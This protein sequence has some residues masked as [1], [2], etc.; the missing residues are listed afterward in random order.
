MTSCA[1][2]FCGGCAGGGA[3][4]GA[5]MSRSIISA[6]GAVRALL[7]E[8]AV[9]QC[10]GLIAARSS[11]RAALSLLRSDRSAWVSGKRSYAQLSV[12]RGAG[13]E[14][15]SGSQMSKP[16]LPPVHGNSIDDAGLHMCS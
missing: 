11:A 2:F 13:N 6:I 15:P 8:V 16:V 7:Y 3:A 5:A 14:E 10:K 1:R 4:A 9:L 12:R